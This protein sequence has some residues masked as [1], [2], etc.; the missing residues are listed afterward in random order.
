MSTGEFHTCALNEDAEVLCWG[1]GDNGRLG[2]GFSDKQNTPVNVLAVSGTDN[3]SW[4]KQ[5]SA[6]KKHTCALN[7]GGKV[8]CWGA[9]NQKQLGV[10]RY[11]NSLFKQAR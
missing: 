7:G 5:V 8:Y 1:S 10:V 3:L 2:N 4:I 9:N 11:H 6:G